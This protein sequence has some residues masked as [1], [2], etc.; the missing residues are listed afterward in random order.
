VP[1]GTALAFEPL[2]LPLTLQSDHFL[3]EID[4]FVEG[5]QPFHVQ[6]L[7]EQFRTLHGELDAFFRWSFTREGERQ[8]GLVEA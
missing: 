2:S 5:R 7:T 4:L 6:Q 3:L 1:T 8:F